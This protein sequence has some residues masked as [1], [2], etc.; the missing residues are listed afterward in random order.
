[1]HVARKTIRC[2]EIPFPNG[3]SKQDVITI[4]TEQNGFSKRGDI[5][6]RFKEIISLERRYDKAISRIVSKKEVINRR[7]YDTILHGLKP[8]VGLA[9]EF[10]K[11]MQLQLL[12]DLRSN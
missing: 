8:A 3:D 10:G 12:N 9:V 5:L 4:F 1:M 6:E 2:Y 7:E 11:I